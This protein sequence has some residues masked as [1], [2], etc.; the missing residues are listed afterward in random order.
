MHVY[1]HQENKRDAFTRFSV[2]FSSPNHFNSSYWIGLTHVLVQTLINICLVAW[3]T[4]LVSSSPTF[5]SSKIFETNLVPCRI[6]VQRYVLAIPSVSVQPLLATSMK[7]RVYYCMNSDNTAT[8]FSTM[9]KDCTV[10]SIA[11]PPFNSFTL[12]PPRSS[13]SPPPSVTWPDLPSLGKQE[14]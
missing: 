7:I 3:L 14:P 12:D 11:A 2:F 9:P 13:P 4:T 10:P 1:F 8:F 5:A 6:A